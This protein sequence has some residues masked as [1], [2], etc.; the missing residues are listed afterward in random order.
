MEKRSLVKTLNNEA[1][2]S[3]KSV[4]ILANCADSDKMPHKVAFY[5]SLHC[6]PKYVFSDIKK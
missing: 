3:L 1:Y 6:F 4:C 2:Q 5:L